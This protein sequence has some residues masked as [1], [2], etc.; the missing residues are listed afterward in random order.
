ME[1]T[2]SCCAGELKGNKKAN[3]VMQGGIGELQ[4]KMGMTG[5]MKGKLGL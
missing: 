5:D 2:M 4:N 1:L 3:D